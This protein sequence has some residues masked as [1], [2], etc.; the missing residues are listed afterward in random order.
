MHAAAAPALHIY[1]FAFV[2]MALQYCGQCTFKA[3]NR[4]EYAIFFSIFRKAVIVVP[5]TFLL[6]YVFHLGV[7]GVYLAEP[8]SN[9]IG[10][11]ACFV[12]MYL[13]VYRPISK[14]KRI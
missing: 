1:F 6:P 9:V 11:S 14:G 5:L 4:K 7:N 10:G 2:F 12:T 13:T 3:L 8:I